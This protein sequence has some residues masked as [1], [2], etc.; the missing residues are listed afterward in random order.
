MPSG[1][2]ARQRATSG[3][4]REAAWPVARPGQEDGV[5]LNVAMCSM[6]AVVETDGVRGK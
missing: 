4:Q 5:G 1:R 3:R 6:S 2:R